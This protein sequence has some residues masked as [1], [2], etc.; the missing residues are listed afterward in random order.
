MHLV[1]A[2]TQVNIMA[3]DIDNIR[4]FLR[5]WGEYQRALAASGYRLGYPQSSPAIHIGE[6]RASMMILPKPGPMVEKVDDAMTHLLYFD[7]QCHTSM[8]HKYQYLGYTDKTAAKDMSVSVQY[9]RMLIQR[10]EFY[11]AGKITSAKPNKA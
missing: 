2:K 6:V 11:V 5:W 7:P 1:S 3:T 8:L 9:Y 4:K 10:G